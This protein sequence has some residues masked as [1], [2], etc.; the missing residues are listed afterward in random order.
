MVINKLKGFLLLTVVWCPQPWKDYNMLL[1]LFSM[2]VH[3]NKCQPKKEN[4]RKIENNS[5]QYTHRK[6]KKNVSKKKNVNKKKKCWNM[7]NPF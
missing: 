4:N 2:S 3:N 7:Y 1:T 6:N 5:K